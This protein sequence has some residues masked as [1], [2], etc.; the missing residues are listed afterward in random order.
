MV[1]GFVC[2][3]LEDLSLFHTPGILVG[4]PGES[5]APAGITTAI[6]RLASESF[7]TSHMH[8]AEGS[9]VPRVK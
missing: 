2:A 1:P 8:L 6:A 5:W 9:H 4:M 3:G 7:K